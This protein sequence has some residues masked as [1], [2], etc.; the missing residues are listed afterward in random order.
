MVIADGRIL[1]ASKCSHPDLFASIRGGGGGAAG[2]RQRLC[3]V[4]ST[5]SVTETAPFLAVLQVVVDFVAKSHPAPRWTSAGG[6]HGT[7]GTEA[8][9]LQLSAEVMKMSAAI[10]VKTLAFAVRFHCFRGQCSAFALR[11][12]CFR[13]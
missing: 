13:G 4:C 3:R 9:C 11:F 8:E 12:H 2:V 5:E 1:T 10:A 6:F 7:A